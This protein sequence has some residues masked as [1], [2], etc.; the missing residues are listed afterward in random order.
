MKII[1]TNMCMVYDN[2]GNI[3]VENRTKEDWPG[4]TFPGGHVEENET[5]EESVIR[6][7]KEETGLDVSNLESMGCIEWI[8]NNVRHLS[9]LYKTNCYSGQ[10]ISSNEGEIMWIKLTDIHDFPLSND[11]DLIVEKMTK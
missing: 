4:L 2:H 11:F 1:L 10:I 6:E 9:L 5:I 8:I 3:L 7:M